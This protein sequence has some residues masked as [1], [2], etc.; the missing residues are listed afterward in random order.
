M[1]REIC[2]D[3]ETFIELIGEPLIRKKMH[4]LFMECFPDSQESQLRLYR[5]KVQS[6]TRLLQE[7]TL[8]KEKITE[9]KESL[10][11]ALAMLE[12]ISED[13]E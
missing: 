1:L 11:H 12:R 2:K 5:D 4:S 8:D 10:Q 9:L 13:T 6:L 3:Y 7:R